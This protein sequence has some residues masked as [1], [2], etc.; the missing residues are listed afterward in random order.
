MRSEPPVGDDLQRMLV[1]MKQNVLER[2][3]PRK[4]RGR[5]TG[6]AIAV[7]ALLA[8]GAAGGG[9]ALGLIPTTPEAAPVSTPSPTEPAR[10]IT[11]SSAPVLITPT[12]TPTPTAPPYSATD[13]STWTI[14]ADGA[15]PATLGSATGADD[16]ALREGLTPAPPL[17][18]DTGTVIYQWGCANPNARIWERSD[19]TVVE[20]VG[21]GVVQT[22]VISGASDSSVTQPE[23][24]PK[25][26]AGVGLGSTLD[27][28]R[29][30][31]PNVVQTRKDP[32]GGTADTFWAVPDGG[33]FIVFQIPADGTSVSRVYVG[34]T[35]E[36]AYDYCS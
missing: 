27:E 18:D 8:V 32:V 12:P 9:V 23:V 28:I 13:W 1:S 2:A 26:L 16:A 17:V 19:G 24:G 11:P 25:T 29:A 21:D 30:A 22:V 36:P 35:D 31:Y 10:T 6:V 14:T 15:G 3:E 7:V 34:A 33:R 20:I 5:R 4:R